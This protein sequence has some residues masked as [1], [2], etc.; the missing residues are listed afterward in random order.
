MEAGS[1]KSREVKLQV[2]S[3]KTKH[4]QRSIESF[5]PKIEFDE[6]MEALR[7]GALKNNSGT[8]GV[9]STT[10]I[11]NIKAGRPRPVG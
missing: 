3:K 7:L 9:T 6:A 2:S 11:V 8:Q 10:T 4:C 1:S 5:F